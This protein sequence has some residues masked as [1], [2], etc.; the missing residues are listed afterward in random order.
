M[1]RALT[2]MILKELRQT[3]R[4]RRM[5]A[6]LI[7]APVV[8][9]ILLGYAVD[10][11]VDR[12]PTAICDQ[13]RSPLSRRLVQALTA[14]T[15]LM[16]VTDTLDPERPL[17]E[18]QARVVVV[19]PSRLARDIEHGQPVQVQVLVDGSDPLKSQVADSTAVQFFFREGLRLAAE[20]L[21][22]AAALTADRPR[23]V[24]R[25]MIR[26]EPRILYNPS[27]KSPVY[28]VPG[29]AAIVL[30][31]ITTVVTAMGIAREKEMG[32]IEQLLITPIRPP[33]LLLGKILPFAAIGLVVAGME[34]A[35]GAHLFNVPVR[36]SLATVALGTAFYLLTTLGIGIFISTVA[37]TQQQAILGSMFFIMPAILLSGFAT[38]IESMPGWVQPLTWINPMR[39]YVELMRACLL[40]GAGFADMWLP[41]TALAVIGV[42]V[43]TLAS[44]R[45]RRQLV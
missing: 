42:S 36:G 23:A 24:M 40:K 14:D 7:V 17:R 33:V 22:A 13:D 25:P 34:V 29:V 6:I 43:L 19:L 31:L 44:L 26:L 1:R 15:T 11:D 3:F 10:L 2:A 38:P 5:A 20:Q 39:Y 12:I 35:I 4:D 27:M 9:L 32:T 21:A 30:L 37:R 16:H 28:M 41:L 18:G 45:F 8:Q